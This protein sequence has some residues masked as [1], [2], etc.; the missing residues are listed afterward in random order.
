MKRFSNNPYKNIV[1]ILFEMKENYPLFH[2][3]ADFQF[4]LAWSMKERFSELD[5]RLEKAMIPDPTSYPKLYEKRGTTTPYIDIWFR[6]TLTGTNYGIELKYIKQ[7][8]D[9]RKNFKVN[10]EFYSLRRENSKLEYMVSYW[11]DVQRL[12]EFKH[13]KIIDHGFSIYL[14]NDICFWK[15]NATDLNRFYRLAENSKAGLFS[16]FPLD[17]K[18]NPIGKK[19]IEINQIYDLNENWYDYSDITPYFL[20]EISKI[21]KNKFSKMRYLILQV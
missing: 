7:F 17:T 21:D 2:S 12:E 14:T 8:S 5:F 6:N 10:D 19:R 9:S 3:E 11:R 20:D 15:P 16:Q 18:G 13:N 4:R 1:D